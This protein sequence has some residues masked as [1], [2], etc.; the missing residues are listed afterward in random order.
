[1]TDLVITCHIAERR[2]Y[3]KPSPDI[4]C[5]KL[6][7]FAITRG[8]L[9]LLGGVIVLLRIG[10]TGELARGEILQFRVGDIP[11]CAG[12]RPNVAR[13]VKKFRR[14]PDLD[15]RQEIAAWREEEY[16]RRTVV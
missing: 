2:V 15:G 12:A 1:M 4:E 3:G 6:A 5:L 11:K 13:P 7:V 14:N 16:E 8:P 9:Q 10:S